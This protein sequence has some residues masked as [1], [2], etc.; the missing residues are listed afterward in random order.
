MFPASKSEEEE[1]DRKKIK[2]SIRQLTAI[3]Y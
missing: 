3:R 1:E 2:G